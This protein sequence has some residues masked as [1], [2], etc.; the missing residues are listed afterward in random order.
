MFTVD[1]G[2]LGRKGVLVCKK[3]LNFSEEK[4]YTK[5]IGPRPHKQKKDPPITTS[6][7]TL[8]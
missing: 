1:G 7:L 6:F 2:F 3:I 4:D 8:L 5:I